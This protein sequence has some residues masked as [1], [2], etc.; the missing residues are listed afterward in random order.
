M[1]RFLPL[2]ARVVALYAPAAL[3][4][5]AMDFRPQQI[6]SGLG[7]V[8]AVTA[9]DMD[10]DGKLD[11]VAVLP[12]SVV[13]YRNP[14]W[15]AHTVYSKPE[16]KDNVCLAVHDI[17]GDGKLDIALGAS[18]QPTNTASGGTLQWLR[19]TGKD[20]L[21][22]VH[23]IAE[24]PTLHRIRWGDVDGDGKKELVVAPLHGRG[25]KGPAWEGAGLRALVFRVP[26]N[27]ARDPWPMEVAD[28][29]LHIGHNLIVE[30]YDGD[31]RDEIW[32]ASRE[33]VHVLKR[34]PDGAWAR[35]KL[36]DGAPGEIKLG[37]VNRGRVVA[38]VEPWHGNGVV[39]YEEPR[40]PLTPQGPPPD[41]K[42]RA[43]LGTLWPH[44]MIEERL[45][46]GHALGWADFDGDGSDELAVGWREKNFGLRVYK[47]QPDG[48]W[49][50]TPVD[51]GKDDTKG[52]MATEDIAI[53]DLNGDGRPDIIAGGRATSN[54]RIYWNE[55]K[56][57]W[58]RHVIST[59]NATYLT[60]V[61]T[62][63]T[64]DG[65]TDIIASGNGTTTLFA[66][67]DW[68]AQ[69][70]LTGPNF[71][72]AAVLDV[73]RDG[74]ADFVGAQYS[75]GLL[76]WIDCKTRREYVIDDAKAGGVDGIHGLALGDVN[77][78]GIPDLAANSAQPKGKFPESLAW[79]DGKSWDGKTLARHVF[80]ERDAP[81]L[82]HYLD[83]GDLDGDGRADI[84]SAAKIPAGGNWFAYWKG[85]S[86]EPWQKRVIA[87]NQEGATNVA[88]ADV[89][90]DGKPDLFCTRGHGVGA[91]WYEGPNWT[92]HEVN[93]SLTGPHS[94]AKGDIDGDGDIDFATV[95]K[96]SF[97][98]AWFEND[99]RGNFR[100]HHIYEDQASYDIRLVDING[101]GRL[102]LLVAGQNS[103]NVV[104]YENLIPTRTT[105]RN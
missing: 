46:S 14:D 32:I 17:D 89:N 97:V 57:Q 33:G 6:G 100:T 7:V 16:D 13:W 74:C 23:A 86:T 69:V 59:R 1:P 20:E 99:G 25:N 26:A 90:G 70:L 88:I 44:T 24:E 4:A 81:G 61:A 49:K 80:A 82:S 102:D 64:G 101:D 47:R 60:A 41:P 75:P 66:A 98:A 40:P 30:D 93:A 42:Y 3:A 27:P 72:H 10:L 54:V 21:W 94:L 76:I 31:G 63:F 22:P 87:T 29:T 104:W 37:R 36:G 79:F 56:P 53:A 19:N 103:G 5:Y 96:D 11:I 65:K 2:A 68:K 45:A 83:I 18:W 34:G 62:D 12:K 92:P 105:P 85:S 9:A 39:I 95:A 35:H 50:G 48:T 8:Y 55:S 91:V 15:R 28:Q 38:T 84:A 73:N 43:P 77:G 52:G 51:E 58:K 67:P 71:I 78:D